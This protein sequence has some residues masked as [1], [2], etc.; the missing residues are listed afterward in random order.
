[1]CAAAIRVL[2]SWVGF[3]FSFGVGTDIGVEVYRHTL[4]QPYQ[5]HVARNTSEVIAGLY[6]AQ[7]IVGYV[8]SPLLQGALALLLSLAILGASIRI[9]RSPRSWPV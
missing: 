9:I 1:M 3:K 8:I 6:K 4:Y 7:L 5:F 2:L